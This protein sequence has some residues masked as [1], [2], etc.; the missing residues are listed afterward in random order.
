MTRPDIEEIEARLG[1]AAAGQ[2]RAVENPYGG[3]AHIETPAIAIADVKS[4]GGVPHPVQKHCL[5]NA[6]LIAHAPTDL[7][8]LL[9]Y[10]KE[11]EVKVKEVE[12]KYNR[13][14]TEF[15]EFR[16]GDCW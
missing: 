7:A 16:T 4:R 6:N 12:A 1:A 13:L 5:A 10:V 3:G 2:W 11:L 14:D 15:Y 8:A 9:A